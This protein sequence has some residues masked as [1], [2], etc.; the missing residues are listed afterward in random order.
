MQQMSDEGRVSSPH[1]QYAGLC[2]DCPGNPAWPHD[3]DVDEPGRVSSHTYTVTDGPKM[4]RE[5]LCIAQAAINARPFDEH[6]KASDLARI[7][8]LIAECDR[9]RPTGPDG[10][11]DDRHTPE[12]GCE[13]I[14]PDADP[15]YVAGP[16]TASILPPT[17]TEGS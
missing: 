12:C 13:L 6:R 11:H 1:R 14:L 16:L 5:T 15:K 2:I 9:K 7:G 4:L 10:K 17:K 8:R 3:Y